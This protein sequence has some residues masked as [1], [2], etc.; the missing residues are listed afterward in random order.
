MLDDDDDD[1]D[2]NNSISQN[3][4]NA[5][6]HEA[7][8]V[9]FPNLPSFTPH[10]PFPL[11]PRIMRLLQKSQSKLKIKEIDEEVDKNYDKMDDEKLKEFWSQTTDHSPETRIQ[12]ANF[13]R[14]HKQNG[15]PRA[16]A[17]PHHRKY[18]TFASDG[19]PLNLNEAK[20]PFTLT[21]DE[22]TNSIVLD[23]SVF[24]YLDTAL[25]DVDIHPN[26]AKVTIKGKV[27]QLVFD[28]EIKCGST[29]VQR[30]KTT[31]HLVLT[32]PKV[33]G[34]VKSNFQVLKHQNIPPTTHNSQK[35]V[36]KRAQH[37][38]SANNHHTT[39]AHQIILKRRPTLLGNVDRRDISMR[40]ETFVNIRAPRWAPIEA[41]F[42]F[43]GSLRCAPIVVLLKYYCLRWALIMMF[44]TS[45]SASI[46]EFWIWFVALGVD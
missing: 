41:L 30:S 2:D 35:W 42:L 5:F 28:K 15:Q 13:T 45:L 19:R 21:E 20:V 27:L 14:R 6:G 22:T 46:D 7:L 11:L 43:Y 36:P 17:T 23:I 18:K 37:I 38:V 29:V 9:P 25:I 39:G 10:L 3:L 24:R 40:F 4:C 31:G 33:N 8:L 1:D 32:M 16:D 26:Y 44:W 34:T 12:M